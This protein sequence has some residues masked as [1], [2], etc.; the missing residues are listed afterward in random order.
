LAVDFFLTNVEVV[1]VEESWYTSGGH[2]RNA[3]GRLTDMA[4]GVLELFDELLL[5]AWLLEFTQVKSDKL[6]PVHCAGVRK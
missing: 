2:G 4:N 5:T 6:S 1:D 3:G